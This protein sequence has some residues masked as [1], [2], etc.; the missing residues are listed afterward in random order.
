MK[1]TWIVFT[2]NNSPVHQISDSGAVDERTVS[3][4]KMMVATQ[5]RVPEA[6]VKVSFREEMTQKS[7]VNP[8]IKLMVINQLEKEKNF[9]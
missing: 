4:E 6:E 3:N 9:S 5:N 7:V 1:R 2:V 8:R